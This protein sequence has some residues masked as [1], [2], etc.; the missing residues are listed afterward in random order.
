MSCSS[1]LELLKKEIRKKKTL[2]IFFPLTQKEKKSKSKNHN[3]SD[4][5]TQFQHSDL[6]LLFFVQFQINLWT[7]TCLSIEYQLFLS[8]LRLQDSE[9]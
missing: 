9:K 1:Y 8:P 3:T 2:A 5:N 6:E 7:K 4:Y